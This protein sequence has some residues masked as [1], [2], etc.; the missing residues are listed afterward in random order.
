MTG[1]G[2]ANRWPEARSARLR[3]LVGEGL[4]AGQIANELG[5][6]LTRNAVISRM[7]RM[8]LRSL[9]PPNRNPPGTRPTRDQGSGARDLGTAQRIKAKAKAKAKANGHALPP[10]P[11][12]WNASLA[13]FNATISKRQRKTFAKLENCSCRWPLWAN[14]RDG[15][16]CGHPSA[17]LTAGRPYCATHARFGA[18]YTRER[19]YGFRTSKYR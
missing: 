10:E 5:E 4:S 12:P 7:I 16:Y 15:F 6:G 11:A 1:A 19:G 14:E 13:E 2:L 3:E 9:N 8:N 18:G 17:D